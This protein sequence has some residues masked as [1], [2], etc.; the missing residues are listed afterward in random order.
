MKIW[1]LKFEV[2]QYDNLE[3]VEEFMFEKIHSF[4]GRKLKA[5]WEPLPVR[6]M[7]PKKKLALSDAPGFIIPVFSKRALDILYPLIQNSAEDLKLLFSE[8]EYYAINVTKILNVVDYSKSIYK[9]YSDGSRI[10]QFQKYSFRICDDL[11]KNDIFKIIDEPR[12]RPFVSD[13]F[14]QT[15]ERNNLTGFKFQLVWDSEE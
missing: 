4:D 15:V 10:M 13:R 12:R 2:D 6:R 1:H 8:G 9:M 5:N 7:E 11:L 3:P 14:K